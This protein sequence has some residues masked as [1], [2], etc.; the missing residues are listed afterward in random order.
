MLDSVKVLMTG[1]ID[2]AGLFPP[3]QLSMSE[4]FSEFAQHRSENDGWMLA[5]FVC[6]ATRLAELEPLLGRLDPDAGK[7]Q[8]S[9]LG[10]GGDTSEAFVGTLERD[11]EEI[12]RVATSH[13]EWL[14]IDQFEVRLPTRYRVGQLEEIVEEASSRLTAIAPDPI[15]PFFECD[16]LSDGLEN[17]SAVVETIAA[18]IRND[19]PAGLKIRCGGAKASAIPSTA[20]V[21][22]A[23][24]TSRDK[25]IPLKATQGLHH[26]IRHFDRH[27]GAKAH[28]FINLF[29]CGMVANAHQDSD[30]HLIKI[31]E[32]EDPSAFSFSEKTV[33]WH[34]LEADLQ[35]ISAA[36]NAGI[37]SFGSCSFTE[38]RDDL[39]ELGLLDS[40]T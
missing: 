32:E 36:R 6:P 9:V 10:R 27:L 12:A 14:S 17:M 26:P 8:L 4:A 1:I 38:P 39:H 25:R 7:L 5:R 20:A 34:H 2:Y 22:A 37:T 15:L 33:A 31:L 28:G 21:A 18:V 16:L 13:H 24:K 11:M 19:R 40:P 3:A 35:Q 23:V 30:D 29:V